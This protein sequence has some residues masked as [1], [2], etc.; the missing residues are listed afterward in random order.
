MAEPKEPLT[1][2]ELEIVRLL[3]TGAGNK[4]IAAQLFLSPNTVKVHLRN[5]FTKL[6][7]TSRTEVSMIAIRNGWITVNQSASS[8]QATTDQSAVQES[9]QT[10]GNTDSRPGVMSGTRVAPIASQTNAAVI[11]PTAVGASDPVIVVPVAPNPQ[12]IPSM[13]KWRRVVLLASLLV[14]MILTAVA[15]PA[16][17]AGSSDTFDPLRIGPSQPRNGLLSRGEA[18][19]WYLRAPLPSA[20]AR[21]VAIATGNHIYVIGGEVNQTV[22]ADVMIYEPLSNTW[23]LLN[24]P[25]PTAVANT[26]VVAVNSRIY[27]AG[28]TTANGSPSNAL[29]AY[30]VASGR[31]DVLAPL[32][33]PI[34]GHAMAGLGN[35]LYLFGGTGDAG[36]TTAGYRYDITQNSWQPIAPMPDPRSL[37]AADTVNDRIYVIGGFSEGRELTTCAFY[38]PASDTWTNCAPMTI[39]R[40]GLGLA[41]VGTN[42]FAIGGG[43]NG[44]IGFNER[45]DTLMDRWSPLETPITSDWQSVA[46]ASMPSEFFVFGGYSNGERLSFAYVYEVF[47]NRVYV[48]AF[49]STDNQEKKP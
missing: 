31:W 14:L 20:R 13:A 49:L 44:F 40:S 35:Q 6:E 38:T 26:A 46:V 8:G 3:G 30:D 33:V 7:A 1:E 41:R 11:E 19:R 2:R 21:G 24:T 22:S 12:A 25:K 16:N 43:S 39:P 5:V 4:D 47:T 29:E 9:P 34:A 37:M 32:P 28:G 27:I 10:P 36:T 17:T 15:V 45:Y 48:P 42:L 23:M 18:S